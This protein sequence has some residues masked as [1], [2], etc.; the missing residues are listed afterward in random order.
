MKIAYIGNFQPSFSTENHVRISLESLGHEVVPLQENG[1][2]ASF[3]KKVAKTSDMVLHTTTWDC[4]P[5]EEV[6]AL[7]LELRDRGTPV[8]GFHLDL[9]WGLRRQRR[10]WKAEPMFH[11]D[12]L[13]STDGNND[14]NWKKMGVNHYWLPA[15]VVHTEASPGR[16]RSTYKADVAF[17]GSD[18]TT[19][20]PEWPYRAKLVSWLR[21]TFRSF[22]NPGG[23]DPK[24]REQKLND[25]YASVD[26][27]VG[28][29]ICFKKEE[30]CYW[31][32]RVYEATGRGALLIMPQLD[33]LED[34]FDGR[35]PMYPWEDFEKLE[36]M[37]HS[38]LDKPEARALVKQECWMI[39]K[40][41]HT[42]RH[43]ME[44]LLSVV[45]S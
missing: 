23:T 41:R 27:T 35:L 30:D 4:L 24:L 11:G 16:L 26:V 6:M 32:D 40:Q 18:G 33:A 1:I 2:H 39:T 44:E 22:R 17:V 5:H 19:Y 9:F 21:S 43:R 28:D 34:Q 37:I 20:H 45:F 14:D 7:W 42:Y 13:F 31:S 8:V 36:G 10:Q 12:W 15:G 38:F 25:F 3:L 29:S